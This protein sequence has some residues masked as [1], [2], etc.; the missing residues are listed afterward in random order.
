MVEKDG[1]H[2]SSPSK[3]TMLYTFVHHSLF[4]LARTYIMKEAS[5]YIILLIRQFKA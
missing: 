5:V 2:A 1:T 4:Q 3:T